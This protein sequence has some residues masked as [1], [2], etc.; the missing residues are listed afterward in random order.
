MVEKTRK[1][2]ICHTFYQLIAVIQIRQTL[3]QDDSVSILITDLSN[4]AENVAK[5]LEEKKVFEKVYFL[6]VKNKLQ[7]N[8]P[9]ISQLMSIKAFV[10]GSQK[11]KSMFE[12]TFDEILFYNISKINFIIFSTLVKGNRNLICSRF[13]EGVLTYNANENECIRSMSYRTSCLIRKILQKQDMLK[14]IKNFY[15]YF[16]NLYKGELNVIQIPKLETKNHDFK[17]LL[18]DIFNADITKLSYKQKFIYFSSV[19]DVECTSP[20]NELDVV[21][22][23]ADIVGHANLIV[24]VHPRDNVER[25]KSKNLIVDKNSNIPWEVINLNYDFS[26]NI[27][28]AALSGSVFLVNLITDN[29]TKTLLV[30]NLCNLKNNEVA[31]TML[32][33]VNELLQSGCAEQILKNTSIINNLEELKTALH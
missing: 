24:K 32:K 9:I 1:L 33:G 23:I 18:L 2:I 19:A 16:P 20:A 7:R 10:F 14:V 3:L 6:K 17:N 4:G 12:N 22:K 27:F 5:R 15:C 8:I 31:D 13:E 21:C 25:F 11:L 30:Y 28:I 26:N 29:P